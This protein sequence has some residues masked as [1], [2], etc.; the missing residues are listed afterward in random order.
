MPRNGSGTYALPQAAFVA[1]TT[2]SSTA[3]NSNFSDI[4]SAVTGSLPRDGQA[5]MTGQFKTADGTVGVPSHSF[6]GEAATGFYRPTAGRIGIAI[7]GVSIGYFDATGFVGSVPALAIPYGMLADFA[8]SGAAPSKWLLCYG[9]AVSRVTYALLFAV[10]GTV[11]GVGNGSTTFNVPDLRGSIGVGGDDMGGVAASRLTTAFFGTDP[12][13]IGNRGGVQSRTLI[14]ANLPAYTPA[15]SLSVTSTGTPD[16]TR[17]QNGSSNLLDATTGG[18]GSP[19]RV[20]PG[21]IASGS[22]I[23]S[24]GILSGNA[25]GGTSTAFANI[26]PSLVVQKIIYAGV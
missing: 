7:A 8:G 23:T 18:F 19:C 21:S 1:G 24:T 12:R 11:H 4:A 10:I 22:Q 9:Q 6:S 26:Q 16:I 14:T 13:V 3:V 17:I 2:I 25:Q 5:S 15:G 20:F